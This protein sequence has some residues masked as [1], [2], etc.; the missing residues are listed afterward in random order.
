ME[1]K[2]IRITKEVYDRLDKLLIHRETF[3]HLIKRLLDLYDTINGAASI[4]G[5]PRAK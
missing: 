1:Y 3:G 2:S 4:I 5:P